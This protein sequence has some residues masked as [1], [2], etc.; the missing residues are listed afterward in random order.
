VT[1]AH[2]ESTVRAYFSDCTADD[3]G[4]HTVHADFDWI[5]TKDGLQL[6]G[7]FYAHRVGYH[8]TAWTTER[9]IWKD[10][11]K[12]KAHDAAREVQGQR[13]KEGTVQNEEAAWVVEQ[14]HTA[15]VEAL[16]EKERKAYKEEY[17]DDDTFDEEHKSVR[18]ADRIYYSDRVRRA[19]SLVVEQGK[20]INGW[21]LRQLM[22]EAKQ[23]GFKKDKKEDARDEHN[24]EQ[25]VGLPLDLV[26]KSRAAQEAEWEAERESKRET[27]EDDSDFE[28]VEE[29]EEG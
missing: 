28:D 2:R 26:L 17:G 14:V 25:G 5:R 16:K 4:P 22:D 10:E 19:A 15:M 12:I 6:K 1:L 18:W 7:Y 29:D 11:E 23:L 20:D 21:T 27:K 3:D 24:T 13:V 8:D 9:V